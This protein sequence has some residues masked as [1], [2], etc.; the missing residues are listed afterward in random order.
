MLKRIAKLL[1]QDW[2]AELR[3]RPI[4]RAVKTIDNTLL[5]FKPLRHY[6]GEVN[7][8]LEK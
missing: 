6:C 4:W 5:R 3:P 1:A 2:Q 7:V 8:Y